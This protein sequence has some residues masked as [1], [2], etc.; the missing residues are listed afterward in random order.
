[1]TPEERYRELR[2]QSE[3]FDNKNMIKHHFIRH[4]EEA[5]DDALEKVATMLDTDPACGDWGQ[6]IRALKTK[7]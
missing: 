1:M 5:V 3:C 4:I 2:D 6:H 7:L